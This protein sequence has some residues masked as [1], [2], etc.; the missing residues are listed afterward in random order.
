MTRNMVAD[1]MTFTRRA[2]LLSVPSV[3]L[4]AAAQA[5]GD[6]LLYDRVHR[7]LN[8]NRSLRIRDLRVEVKDGVVTIDGVVRSK[9]LK[10]RA[11]KIA[12][13]KGVQRVNNRLVVGN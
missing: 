1:V 6:D 2:L 9:K 7:K 8:N 12:S 4:C 11:S 3:A 10:S 13:V 5:I